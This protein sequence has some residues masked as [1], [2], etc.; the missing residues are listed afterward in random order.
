MSKGLVSRVSWVVGCAAVGLL[1]GLPVAIACSLPD[2]G[3]WAPPTVGVGDPDGF[4]PPV[5]DY[6][7]TFTGPDICDDSSCYD[8]AILDLSFDL[9]DVEWPLE[10][11]YDQAQEVE[12]HLLPGYEIELMGDV[13]C[14]DAVAP[15]I[16]QA[17]ATTGSLSSNVYAGSVVWICQP[18]AGL[19][20]SFD[21]R[22]RVKDLHGEFG[23]WSEWSRFQYGGVANEDECDGREAPAADSGVTL[24][25]EGCSAT[26]SAPTHALP[27]FVAVV[28]LAWRRRRR[29]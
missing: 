21:A 5:Q 9:G 22:F 8:L 6:S 15:R 12:F 13:P 29:V 2:Y 4:V 16:D 11:S 3:E 1:V 17:R 27:C 19:T 10:G 7:L 24:D 26:G 25:E 28:A 20:W 14:E 18:T 23:E